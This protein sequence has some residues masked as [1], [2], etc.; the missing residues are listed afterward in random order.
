MSQSYDFP[1]KARNKMPTLLSPDTYMRR[2]MHL[3]A[4]GAAPIWRSTRTC[5][6][7]GNEPLKRIAKRTEKRLLSYQKESAH[8]IHLPFCI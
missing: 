4:A 2:P 3:Y 8:A 5:L 1:L 6:H 7:T